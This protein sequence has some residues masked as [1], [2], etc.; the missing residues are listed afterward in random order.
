MRRIEPILPGRSPRKHKPLLLK[1]QRLTSI[2]LT[3]LIQSIQTAI[4]IAFV[5]SIGCNGAS[6]MN[7]IETMWE[8]LIASE[9][10]SEEREIVEQVNTYMAGKRIHVNIQAVNPQGEEIGLDKISE[11][12]NVIIKATFKEGDVSYKAPDWTP[13]NHQNVFILFRE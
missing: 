1:N 3:I 10:E 8:H 7:K 11:N 13:R 2:G 12:R 9:T 6:K 5:L 4:L